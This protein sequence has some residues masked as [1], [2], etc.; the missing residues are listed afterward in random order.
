MQPMNY[1]IANGNPL[2]T[3]LG[4]VKDYQNIRNN[5]NVLASQAEANRIKQAQNDFEIEGMNALGDVDFN[6]QKSIRHWLGRYGSLGMA[7]G[8]KDYIEGLEAKEKQALLGDMSMTVS[9]LQNGRSDLAVADLRAKANAYRNGGN[10]AKALEY[11]GFVSQ[12]ENDPVSAY[13]GLSLVLASVAGKD[14]I[15]GYETLIKTNRPDVRQVDL[16]DKIQTYN[17]NPLT[18]EQTLG[19]MSLDKG[20][21]PDS[22]LQSDTQKYVS[23]NSYNASV[24]GSDMSA[25]AS[26]YGSD[27]SAEASMYGADQAT[28]RS[29]AENQSR[30]RVAQAEM[31][32]KQ[33]QAE[34]ERNLFKPTSANG[35][36]WLVN[37]NGEFKPMLDGNGNQMLDTDYMKSSQSSANRKDIAEIQ[38]QNDQINQTIS[39][40]QKAK[41]LSEKGI[42]DGY[43]ANGRADFMGNFWGGTEESKRTQEYNNLITGSALQSMKAIF[44]GNPTEGERAILLKIQASVEYPADVRHRI[45]EEG[46]R[47]AQEKLKSNQRQIAIM[48][49]SPIQNQQQQTQSTQGSYASNKYK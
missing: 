31:Y 21:S 2:D 7:K 6:D 13:N 19:D 32:Y 8:A 9:L 17:V 5:A 1:L 41:N 35:K 33:Q 14:N 44:G 24:Y 49:G 30:E 12:M 40:L 26:M 11:E 29:I 47:M 37:A 27:R 10:E 48:Q 4:Y 46:I 16:G 15:S 34:I 42:Y 23:D 20:V 3:I 28:S 38:G 39:V 25:K 45:L 36:M 43:V 18:G 22:Q